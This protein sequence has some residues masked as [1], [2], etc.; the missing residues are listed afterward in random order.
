VAENKKSVT[1]APSYRSVIY[2]VGLVYRPNPC[3][4][5]EHSNLCVAWVGLRIA[6]GRIWRYSGCWLCSA[7]STAETGRCRWPFGHLAA[8][9][10]VQV[11]GATGAEWCGF[12]Q[13]A[14]RQ[15]S[16][17]LPGVMAMLLNA[18]Q[19][20][21]QRLPM[22]SKGRAGGKPGQQ[23]LG[24][25]AAR[26][27]ILSFFILRVIS[28]AFLSPAGAFPRRLGD[29]RLLSVPIFGRCPAC[30]II[31]G[32]T[33]TSGGLAPVA[34]S[35][36]WS[37]G[38]HRRNPSC[39]ARWVWAGKRAMQERTF[40]ARLL[41]GSGTGDRGRSSLCLPDPPVVASLLFSVGSGGRCVGW[42]M[43]GR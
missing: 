34:I 29:R 38:Q 23:N 24:K 43:V 19:L 7:A 8:R 15:S 11:F 31:W 32:I 14:R 18:G 1:V 6:G 4:P 28:L 35:L 16:S 42:Q 20:N 27:D 17:F 9:S 12:P 3:P 13:L 10:A 37:A 22:Q 40:V 21:A 26:S 2:A 30:I 33:P 25:S 36:M 5:S 39:L 41:Y